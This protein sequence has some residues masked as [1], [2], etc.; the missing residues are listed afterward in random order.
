MCRDE[1]VKVLEVNANLSIFDEDM[2]RKKLH[3]RSQ[4]PRPLDLKFSAPITLVQRYVS[5]KLE[6][7]RLSY[8]ETDGRTAATLI[9]HTEDRLIMCYVT[10]VIATLR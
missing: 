7:L 2:G 4:W 3:F 9:P 5:A 10:F 8:F 6:F 1:P